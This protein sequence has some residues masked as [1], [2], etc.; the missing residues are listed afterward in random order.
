MQIHLTVTAGPHRGQSFAFAGHDVFLVGRSRRAHFRLPEGDDFFSRIHFLVEINPPHCHLL[1]MGSKNGTRLNGR[2]VSSADLRDGDLIQAGTTVLR[3]SVKAGEQPSSLVLSAAPSPTVA[4][5][6]A[7][8][9]LPIPPPT[10]LPQTLS[11]GPGPGATPC[12]ACGQ[13]AEA[14]TLCS[15]CEAQARLQPQPVP[16]YRVVR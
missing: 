1:D 6:P 9:S 12:P 15:F 13:P 11:T 5:T 16:G 10:R 4:K 2:P 3:V 7:P 8:P 14:G